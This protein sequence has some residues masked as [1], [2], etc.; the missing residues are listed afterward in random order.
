MLI[1]EKP[2]YNDNPK[3]FHYYL[4]L[5][6]GNDL[7]KGLES[8]KKELIQLIK[9]I[10]NE[11][12]NYEYEKGKWSTK[13]VIQHIIDCERLFNYRAFRFSRFDTTNLADFDINSTLQKVDS[14]DLDLN[15]LIVEFSNLRE[16]T[17]SLF[18]SMSTEMLDFKGSASNIQF[19]ARGLGYICIGHCIHHVN[20]IKEMYLK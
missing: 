8:N 9:T 1:I 14:L 15:Q 12:E 19:T 18:Q 17:I 10:P 16:S 2:D 5:M 3:Y 4:D 20:V 7:L 6:K 11:L 13:K